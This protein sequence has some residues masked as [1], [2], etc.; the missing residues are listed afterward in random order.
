MAARTVAPRTLFEIQARTS[1]GRF[2]GLECWKRDCASAMISSRY[3]V[4]WG[5][6]VVGF[7]S[8][9]SVGVDAEHHTGS[10]RQYPTME[11]GENNSVIGP[12]MIRRLRGLT[13]VS[14]DMPRKLK[15]CLDRTLS[16]QA[17]AKADAARSTCISCSDY[18]G[19]VVNWCASWRAGLRC[20]NAV[21]RWN[22]RVFACIMSK[23]V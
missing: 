8:G 16:F 17:F 2:C 18:N 12:R 19:L 23:A 20:K 15:W 21:T 11:Q 14:T 13:R 6:I 5:F 1:C 3:S 7:M 9:L 22:C 10:G 4:R